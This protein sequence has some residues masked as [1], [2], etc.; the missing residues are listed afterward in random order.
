[1]EEEQSSAYGFESGNS[2]NIGDDW[3][4]NKSNEEDQRII[5][6]GLQ[7]LEWD[8]DEPDD[9]EYDHGHTSNEDQRII[10]L[11][12]QLLEWAGEEPDEME[13]GDIPYRQARLH[14]TPAAAVPV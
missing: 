3:Y 9:M 7:L 6:P 10:N 11:G 14:P 8:G 2:S 1:M 4:K 13:D 5:S 12:L